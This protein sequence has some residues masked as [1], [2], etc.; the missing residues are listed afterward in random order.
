M[1]NYICKNCGNILHILHGRSVSCACGYTGDVIHEYYRYFDAS[2]R[3]TPL[4]YLDKYKVTKITPQGVKIA[5]PDGDKFI[6]NEGK[7]KYAYPTKEEAWKGFIK[8][9]QSRYNHVKNY[10]N[11]V[12]ELIGLLK[13]CSSLEEYQKKTDQVTKFKK[14][15]FNDLFPTNT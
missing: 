9:K 6:L 13:N 7:K 11:Y 5:H 4:I 8:R 2:G 1:T 15:S 12:H 10:Y 14:D 3:K